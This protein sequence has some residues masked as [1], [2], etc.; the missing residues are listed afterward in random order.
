MMKRL[1]PPTQIDLILKE[2]ALHANP[3][4]LDDIIELSHFRYPKHQQF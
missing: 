3:I 4:C 2:I 1:L